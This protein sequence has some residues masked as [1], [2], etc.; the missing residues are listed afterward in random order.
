MSSLQSHLFAHLIINVKEP[1]KY[2]DIIEIVTSHLNQ[3]FPLI[4]QVLNQSVEIMDQ[5]PSCLELLYNV[6]L[7]SVTGSM[8]FKILSSLLLMPMDFVRS[9]VPDLL[10]IM[11]PLDRFNKL[12]PGGILIDS[13]QPESK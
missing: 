8:F 10:N 5:D 13:T 4:T 1:N 7:D 11:L 9:L 12:L 2:F 3:L 6:L